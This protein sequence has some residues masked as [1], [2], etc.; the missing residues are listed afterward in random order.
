MGS[1][2]DRCGT[3]AWHLEDGD[4]LTCLFAAPPGEQPIRVGDGPACAHYEPPPDCLD[5]GA[6]C[7][8]AFDSVP[9]DGDAQDRLPAEL[10]VVHDDGWVDLARVPS[11]TGCGTRCAA[12][13]GDGETAPYTCVVYTLRPD[14]CRDVKVG[15]E[16]CLM[17]RRR[18]GLAAWGP[19]WTPSG[20]GITS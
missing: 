19:G 5:C 7:R 12:L 17:A 13:R 11:P 20:P 4:W 14:T 2:N 9:V 10:V 18:V 16:G 8:E 1:P 6:C 3:C 15:S